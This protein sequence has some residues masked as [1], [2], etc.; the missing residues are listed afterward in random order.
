MK[1]NWILKK[2][3][4][5]TWQILEGNVVHDLIVPTLDEGGI[6]GTKRYQTFASQTSCK[7]HS[8]LLSN[9]NI[10]RTLWEDLEGIIS[11]N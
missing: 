2:K 10:K 7:G 11:N 8:M 4:S 5:L 6:D 1:K 3:Q 9:S